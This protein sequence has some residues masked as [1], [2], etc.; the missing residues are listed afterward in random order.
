MTIRA[1][2]AVPLLCGAA[3]AVADCGYPAYLPAVLA[4]Q[5]PAADPSADWVL[6]TDPHVAGGYCITA[7][8]LPG[9]PPT[10]SAIVA[11]APAVLRPLCIARLGEARRAAIAARGAETWPGYGADEIALAIV[12]GEPSPAIVADYT[13]DR[14]AILTAYQGQT[15]AVATLDADSAWTCAQTGDMP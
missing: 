1:A 10:A 12:S 5:H 6:G 2:L 9:S 14:A 4:A 13:A 8:S 3:L 15:A 11:A 7:W